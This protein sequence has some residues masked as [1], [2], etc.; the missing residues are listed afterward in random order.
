VDVHWGARS[1]F[2]DQAR[3]LAERLGMDARFAP[4]YRL[5][6][7]DAAGPPREYG[8]ALLSRFPVASFRNDTIMRLS[9][10]D[11]TRGPAPA[12]GF[13]NATV[14]VGGQEIRVFNTHTDFRP[15]PAVRRAQVAGMLA[16]IGTP[17]MPTLLLGDLNAPPTAPELR[18]LLE[19]LRDAWPPDSGNGFTYPAS[20]PARRI[21]Y[22]LASPHFRVVSARVLPDTASDHRG[23]VVDLVRGAARPAA[24][25]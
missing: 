11:S 20:A 7:A 15:D 3:W 19:R 2:A 17:A 21:D 18:P 5:P 4:I 25:P 13:L 16:I 24:R 10:Q 22:V 12:P 8:V 14:R 1:R 6:A 9:T 23:V